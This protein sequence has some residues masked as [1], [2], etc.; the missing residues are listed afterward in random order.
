MST[1]AHTGPQRVDALAGAVVRG[2]IG[3]GSKSARTAVWIETAQGRYLLR[4]QGGPSHGDVT[5]DRYV[6][7]RVVCSGFIV[8][9]SLL[10]DCIDVA[11]PID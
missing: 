4:R 9:G 6:G 5:L 8:G 1:A 3:G 10:A 7:Q 2:P 11:G